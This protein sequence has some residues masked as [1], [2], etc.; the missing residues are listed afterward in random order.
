MTARSVCRLVKSRSAWE[1]SPVGKQICRSIAYVAAT[2]M[3]TIAARQAMPMAVMAAALL[4]ACAVIN[5]KIPVPLMTPPAASA[6]A[7]D[8]ALGKVE[9]ALKVAPAP[10]PPAVEASTSTGG[11]LP[12]S[13]VEAGAEMIAAVNLQQ[14]ALPTFVQIMYA[15]ILKKTV[16]LHPAVS[17]RQDLVTFR[18]GGGQTAVQLEIATRLL[19]KSY[20]ISVIDVGGLIRVVP[21]NANLGDLPSIRYG[22]AMPDV[23]LPLR[24][25][26]NMVQLEAVRQT[27]VSNWLRTMFGDRVTVQEDAGRNAVLVSGNP[28]NVK[29]ALE[30]IAI[31]DQPAM[32]GRASLALSPAYWSADELARRLAELLSAEGYAVHPVG[33]PITAAI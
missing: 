1:S 20:G 14:V 5:P 15:E 30:A 22:A 19:L 18:T 9:R 2:V 8:S 24:P 32:K 28:D 23:P 25:V 13:S 33:Q 10:K 12:A 11:S 17:S 7:D 16:N 26:F 27:D 31:L 21:D 29:A 6:A 3:S 4:N